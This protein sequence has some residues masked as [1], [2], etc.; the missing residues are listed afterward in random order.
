M[1]SL[2][3]VVGGQ[4]GEWKVIAPALSRGKNKYCLCRCSCG[5][6][7]S[8]A[9]GSL[10]SGR[11]TN[12]G[13]LR[14]LAAG[15]ASR[16]HGE[17]SRRTPEYRAYAAMIQRCTNVRN[18][19]YKDYGGRGISVCSRWLNSYEAFLEDMG[20]KP[21]QEY[22]LDRIDNARGYSPENCRW[23][24]RKEQNRNTRQNTC[25]AFN[26][27][28]LPL[29]AWAE[30]MGIPYG[31]LRSRLRYGWPIDKALTQPVNKTKTHKGNSHAIS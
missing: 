26:G 25:V 3:K 9:R 30:R 8:V 1:P 20:R 27:E 5:K 21:N 16:T 10:T 24:T 19:A 22:S 6:E 11:S 28:T 18:P 31:S 12:C 7:K 2:N 13:C 29:S 17:S 14:N 4:Y 15:S 23:A